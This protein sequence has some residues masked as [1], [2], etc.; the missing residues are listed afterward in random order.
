MSILFHKRGTVEAADR[1]IRPDFLRAHEVAQKLGVSISLVQS[2]LRSKLLPG[3]KLG[4][5]WLVRTSELEKYLHMK[6]G[7]F[8]GQ[9]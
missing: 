6:E 2:L 5:V 4:K 9:E 8:S 7:L 3:F 1:T